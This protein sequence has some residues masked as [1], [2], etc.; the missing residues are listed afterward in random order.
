MRSRLVVVI[1]PAFYLRVSRNKLIAYITVTTTGG[2]LN[3]HGPGVGLCGVGLL[4]R[5][6][7]P[8]GSI[9]CQGKRF[10]SGA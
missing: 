3:G 9:K 10:F 1:M 4:N 6:R 5:Y 8:V 7:G 2:A